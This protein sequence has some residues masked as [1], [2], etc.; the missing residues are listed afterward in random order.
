VRGRL[1]LVPDRLIFQNK[2]KLPKFPPLPL[3]RSRFRPVESFV[4]FKFVPGL[5]FVTN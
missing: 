2:K 3:F 1:L 4:F 5:P